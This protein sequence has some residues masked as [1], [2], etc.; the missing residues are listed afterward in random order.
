VRSFSIVALIS[1]GAKVVISVV[2]HHT[3]NKS[4]LVKKM[5]ISGP[6][7]DKAGLSQPFCKPNATID[8]LF[9]NESGDSPAYR[10][11]DRH[12]IRSHVRK[13]IAR[14]FKQKHKTGQKKAAKEPKWT[15]LASKDPGHSASEF[16]LQDDDCPSALLE[17]QE[18][19]SSDVNPLAYSKLT[20]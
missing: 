2:R 6:S 14:H 17:R 3:T 20:P 11:G 13:H 1:L 12:D 16:P 4:T 10:V 9:V 8:F 7:T 5:D 15:Q 18:L 19:A